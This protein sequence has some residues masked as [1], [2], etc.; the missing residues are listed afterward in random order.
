MSVSLHE[1]AQQRLRERLR[2]IQRS[3]VRVAQSIAAL[4]DQDVVSSKH[5]DQAIKTLLLPSR[6]Q[7]RR[8]WAVFAAGIILGVCSPGI[9]RA[10]GELT[11]TAAAVDILGLIFYLLAFLS[12]IFL[13][14]Y[15]NS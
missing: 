14:L 7:Q 2:E 1:N 6:L 13:A 3:I 12:G 10:F 9:L 15:G 4:E 5:I 11:T 8:K